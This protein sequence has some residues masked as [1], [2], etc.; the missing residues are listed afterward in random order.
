MLYHNIK[1]QSLWYT[2]QLKCIVASVRVRI[3]SALKGLAD[4]VRCTWTHHGDSLECLW[5]APAWCV[6]LCLCAQCMHANA[7]QGR[8]EEGATAQPYG[9]EG[10]QRRPGRTELQ[11][12]TGGSRDRNWRNHSPLHH[13]R[14]MLVLLT[15]DVLQFAAAGSMQ[16]WC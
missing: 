4:W 3:G 13:G 1:T 9:G 5:P 2:L 16:L 6:P 14:V 11:S 15:I 10:L 7:A 8:A 12:S